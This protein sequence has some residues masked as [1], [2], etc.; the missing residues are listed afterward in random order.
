MFLLYNNN[1]HQF[2]IIN[3]LSRAMNIW[4][5]GVLK[6]IIIRYDFQKDMK[7]FLSV[8]LYNK[9]FMNCTQ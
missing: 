3:S 8:W 9:N 6:N 7:T 2:G 5:K 1:N 4:C